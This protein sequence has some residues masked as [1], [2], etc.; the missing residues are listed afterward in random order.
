MSFFSDLFNKDNRIADDLYG[1]SLEDRE[2]ILHD[3]YGR[4]KEEFPWIDFGEEDSDHYN[5]GI[6]D[7]EDTDKP[8]ISDSS[9]MTRDQIWELGNAGIDLDDLDMMDNDERI[10]ALELAGLDP[11]DFE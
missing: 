7:D 10:E 6:G 9:F 2:T 11:D 4:S 5:S 8:D 3:R 1:Y